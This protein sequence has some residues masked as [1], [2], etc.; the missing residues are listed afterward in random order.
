ME[1]NCTICKEKFNTIKFG[2]RREYCF[3]C[4]PSE[5]LNAP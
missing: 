2:G 1:K 3:K 5:G 4:L